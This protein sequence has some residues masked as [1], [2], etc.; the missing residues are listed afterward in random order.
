MLFGQSPRLAER[1]YSVSGRVKVVVGTDTLIPVKR[2]VV[3]IKDTKIGSLTDSLGNFAITHLDTGA[4]HIQ[5]LGYGYKTDSIVRIDNSSVDSLM[6][7]A[8]AECSV[9]GAF[10]EMDIQDE[11][12]CLIVATGIVP[13]EETPQDSI[14]EQKYGILF[15]D[16]GHLT[17]AMECMIQYN[18]TIFD[19]LDFKF[20]T[21]WRREIRR[22]V[23]GLE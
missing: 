11:N 12:M 5:V 4:V 17:P 19:H 9:N 15:Y 23:L 16:Y 13:V 8:Q 21:V 3:M 7:Y 1:K 14:F 6:L 10:A 18:R 22:D 2:P 20:G